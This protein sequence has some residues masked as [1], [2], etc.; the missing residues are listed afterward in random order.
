MQ[1]PKWDKAN[2][3]GSLNQWIDMLIEEARRQF[4]EAGTH[5]EIFFIFNDEG[6]MEVVPIAGM[7]KDDM[8]RNLKLILSERDGYAFIHIAEAIARNMDSDAQADSLM[9]H[10]ESRASTPGNRSAPVTNDGQC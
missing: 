7:D 4:L 9:L 10:A 1:A 5:V 2:K 8:V 3:A 6:L